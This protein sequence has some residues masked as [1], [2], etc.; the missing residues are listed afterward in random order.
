[1]LFQKNSRSGFYKDELAGSRI[2][3]RYR[4]T[5][6]HIDRYYVK[7]LKVYAM[8][9]PSFFWPFRLFGFEDPNIGF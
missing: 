6:I 3:E 8:N 4:P 9:L 5:K 7:A 2:N 1:M